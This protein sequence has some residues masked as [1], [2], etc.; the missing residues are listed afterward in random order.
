MDFFGVRLHII[1][2]C[3]LFLKIRNRMALLLECGAGALLDPRLESCWC[4]GLSKGA[5]SV[6]GISATSGCA[7]W[8]RKRCRRETIAKSLQTLSAALQGGERLSQSIAKSL[9]TFSAALQVG[10]RLLQSIAKSSPTFSAAL[11]EVQEG[12]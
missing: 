12:E 6:P 2:R 10:E 1:Q 7:G 9:P 8:R 4:F 3:C 11:Q 5:V